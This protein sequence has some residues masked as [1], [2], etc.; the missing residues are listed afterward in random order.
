MST[1]K[2]IFLNRLEN[3]ENALSSTDLI[4]GNLRDRQHNEK[5]RML[6]NGMAIVEYTILEDFIK[7]RIGEVLKEIGRSGISFNLL[8]AKLKET[9]V[10]SALKGI[11]TR[12]DNL[13]R[14]SEV[15]L[16]LS[17]PRQY[18]EISKLE[19]LVLETFP[20]SA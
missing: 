18:S 9:A 6:R 10:L 1:A 14:A 3:F 8:P 17:H 13:K 20:V 11:Q 12:A 15:I 4:S 19:S 7:K 16:G 2:E 5:A